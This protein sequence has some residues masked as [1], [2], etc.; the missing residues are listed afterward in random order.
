MIAIDRRT[1]AAFLARLTASDAAFVVAL[2][3]ASRAVI[4]IAFFIVAPHRHAPSYGTAATVSFDVFAHWDGGWFRTVVTHGYDY[5]LDR[6]EH[7]I[8]F[9]PLYPLVVAAIVHLGIAFAP[10]AALASNAFFLAMLL[11]VFDWVRTRHDVT[12]ARWTVATLA[13]MP[14]A[15]FGAVAY[16]ESLFM[17][18]SALALRDFDRDRPLRAAFW[19]VLAS[20]TRVAGIG[21]AAGFALSALVERRQPR[22]WLAA[23]LAPLGTVAFM[24]YQQARFGDALAFVHSEAAWRKLGPSDGWVR[25]FDDTMIAHRHWILALAFA[26]AAAVYARTRTRFGATGAN[27]AALALVL[28]LAKLWRTGNDMKLLFIFVAAYAVARFRARLGVAEFG[29][30]LATFALLAAAGDPLSTERYAW[31]TLPFSLALAFLW[32]RYP[33]VGYVTLAVGTLQ[34]ALWAVNFAQNVFVA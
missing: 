20:A 10:A 19:A 3:L 2:Y 5:A 26:I 24:I 27:L 15:L 17:L 16:S 13:L 28:V 29:F 6:H 12:V 18:A 1:R 14:P 31:A 23:L 33:R 7:S 25:I 34:L 30:A 4:A 9:F 22:V 21:L 32:Q 11:V 8:A